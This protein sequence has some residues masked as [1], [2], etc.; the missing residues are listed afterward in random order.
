MIVCGRRDDARLVY[1][2]MGSG[3]KR[4]NGIFVSVSDVRI[5]WRWRVGGA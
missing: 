3:K 1:A 5:P 4:T 2:R